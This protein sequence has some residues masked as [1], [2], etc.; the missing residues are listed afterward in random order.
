MSVKLRLLVFTDLHLHTWK[1]F[2]ID[3]ESGLTRRLRDQREVLQ[4]V[5]QLITDRG[6]ELVLFGGDLFHLVGVLPVEAISVAKSFFEKLEVLGVEHIEC[7][8]NHDIVDRKNP[9]W[10]ENALNVIKRK[11]SSNKGIKCVGYQDFVVEDEISGYD[12]VLLHKTPV[13]AVVGNYVFNEGVD[14]KKLSKRNKLVFFGHIHQPQRLSE[15]CFVLG[16]VMPLNFGDVG[17]RGVYIVD[18]GKVEFVKLKYPEFRTVSSLNEI[19]D[20]NYY[21]VIGVDGR[22]KEM[23][24]NVVVVN[25]SKSFAERIKSDSFEG[26]LV[27]WLEL[28][29]KDKSYLEVIKD[30]IVEKLQ[31]TKVITKSNLRKVRIKDFLCVGE[32]EYEVKPGFV[33]VLGKNE[34]GFS[35]NGSGKTTVVGD[36]LYWALFG[37]TT[38]GLVGDDVVKDGCKDCKVELIFDDG[39]EIKRTRKELS[40][41]V[42]GQE[43]WTGR[44]LVDKQKLLEDVLGF[45]EVLFMSSC[46]FSQ[47]RL[48]MLTSLGDADRTEL[49]V[50]LL[51]FEKYDELYELVSRKMD[52][53]ESEVEKIDDSIEE[54]KKEMMFFGGQVDV[55][56]KEIKECEEN[57]EVEQRKLREIRDRLSNK[58]F[59]NELNLF[60]EKR[61]AVKQAIEDVRVGISKVREEIDKVS[62]EFANVVGM[63]R[64]LES[65][66]LG[67]SGKIENGRK[68]SV[69]SIC[70]KCGSVVS[71]ESLEQLISSFENELSLNKSKY[72][73]LESKVEEL[74]AVKTLLMEKVKGLEER[75]KSLLEEE[76]QIMEG[77][78]VVEKEKQSNEMKLSEASSIEKLIEKEQLKRERLM[79]QM[80]EFEEKVVEKKREIDNRL[81]EREKLLVDLEGL[82]FWKNAFSNRGIKVLLLEKFCNEFNTLLSEIVS[83]VS[84][85]AL[86]VHVSPTAQLKSGEERNRLNLEIEVDG[87]KRR[88]EALSGG[89]K[90]R[91]DIGLCLALNKWVSYKYG[92]PKGIL[93]VLVLDE[94]F[95]FIDASGEESI[96]N[97]LSREGREKAVFVVTHTDELVSYADRFMTVVKRNGISTVEQENLP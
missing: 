41:I 17:D 66:I 57:I 56:K 4:Q 53:I 52:V 89:E 43:L 59:E 55:L 34:D 46:Y 92:V 67:L 94:L 33:L 25:L 48:V 1:N 58:D 79:K 14:W 68:V 20:Y 63:K 96:G 44:K 75:E 62:D 39:M 9:K 18:D 88:Y 91:V 73:V 81:K 61:K 82:E 36:A 8:G 5:L 7:D 38:K 3:Q 90:R 95:S 21:R 51:G 22:S 64:Y 30:I 71:K 2:G 26:M 60:E 28:Q 86:S 69:G 93:G 37:K 6:I 49:I 23:S 47:E 35:S 50:N 16:S 42:G 19:D 10:F 12:I 85:G 80:D 97:V 65:V 27:E 11:K 15:N 76:S 78:S 24:K 72:E 13:G 84:G 83:D 29:K 31:V 40:V 70:D 77:I 54:I 45:D 32:V 87:V 74:K